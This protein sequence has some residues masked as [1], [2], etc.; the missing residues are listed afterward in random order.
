V[1]D[2]ELVFTPKH[3]LSQKGKLHIKMPTDLPAK[4]DIVTTTGGIELIL[5]CTVLNDGTIVLD[6]P[7]RNN[8]FLGDS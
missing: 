6:N 7:F 3:P 1:T 5:N 4:C 8:A 2:V